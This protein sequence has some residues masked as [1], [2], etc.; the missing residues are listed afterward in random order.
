MS[1]CLIYWY[2]TWRGYLL[3]LGLP[4]LPGFA[5]FFFFFL[6]LWAGCLRRSELCSCVIYD[7]TVPG[8]WYQV[9]VCF[10]PT[11]FAS[12]NVCILLL[13]ITMVRC[14]WGKKKTGSGVRLF[15]AVAPPYGQN[16]AVTCPYMR[17]EVSPSMFFGITRTFSPAFCEV[18]TGGPRVQ[19][20]RTLVRC[21]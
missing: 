6:P 12:E 1:L 13:H 5:R 14:L 16:L 15:Y 18:F 10:F 3:V 17:I 19:G 21:W 20:F 2:R 8:I 9:L 7:G 4:D 11:S